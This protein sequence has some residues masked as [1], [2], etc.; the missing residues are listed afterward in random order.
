MIFK[1]NH[2][3]NHPCIWHH[4]MNKRTK[5]KN[6]SIP[7]FHHTRAI[8]PIARESEQL[9][10]LWYALAGRWW[11]K[12]WIHP[13]ISPHESNWTYSERIRTVVITLVCIRWSMTWRFHDLI[14][15]PLSYRTKLMTELP[16]NILRMVC[17]GY[18]DFDAFVSETQKKP[19]FLMMTRN[20]TW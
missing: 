19:Q 18:L 13:C 20:G 2:P 7:A 11:P 9:W 15:W 16:P 8:E 14:F 10:S 3:N 6:E 1:W 17:S 5:P 12:K 4:S